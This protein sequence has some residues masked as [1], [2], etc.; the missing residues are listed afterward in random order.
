MDGSDYKVLRAKGMDSPGGVAIDFKTNRVLWV[1]SMEKYI[2]SM[3]YSGENYREFEIIHQRYIPQ[4]LG[5]HENGLYLTGIQGSYL[6]TPGIFFKNRKDDE[7]LVL[8]LSM[9]TSF[10]IYSSLSQPNYGVENACENHS[11]PGICLVSDYDSF[12]CACPIGTRSENNGSTCAGG[13]S[14]TQSQR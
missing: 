12:R 5:V 1:D 10:T 11:C 4:H 9:P 8:N 13:Q 14:E 6:D 2:G 3:D 7:K